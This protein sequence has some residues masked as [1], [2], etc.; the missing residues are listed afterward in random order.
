MSA[1]YSIKIFLPAG[2]PNGLRIL[3]RP[4]WTG[5]GVAFG[6]TG[7]KEAAT[8]PELKRTGVYI[9]VGESSDE[10]P[11]PML[12]I[13]E[14]DPILDRLKM[15][16]ANKDFWT[17][18]VAFTS[19]DTSLNKAHVQHLESRLIEIAR[20]AKLCKLENSVNPTQ[21]SLT[22]ADCA[23]TEQFLYNTGPLSSIQ[24]F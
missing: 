5:V 15:H 23:D 24:R 16:N 20:K 17:F 11:L 19:K 6:R 3:E 1:P 2:E 18:G 12:Y 7:F 9:L 10:S 21:P 14:G 4:N 22:E 13:G 8:R